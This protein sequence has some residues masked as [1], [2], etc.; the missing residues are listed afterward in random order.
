MVVFCL[1]WKQHYL[2][3]NLKRLLATFPVYLR[4]ME[5]SA[6]IAKGFVEL[7]YAA[8]KQ[9]RNDALFGQMQKRNISYGTTFS[10]FQ[11]YRN[12]TYGAKLY[13][14]LLFMQEKAMAPR[15]L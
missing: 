11:I 7:H 6:K 4:A 2:K 8:L 15:Y 13:S 10:K 5:C 14:L 3:S 9:T 1:V 12:I